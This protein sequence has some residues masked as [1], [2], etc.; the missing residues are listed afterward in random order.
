[1]MPV[2]ALLGRPAQRRRGIDSLYLPLCRIARAAQRFVRRQRVGMLIVHSADPDGGVA[3]DAVDRQTNPL[4]AGSLIRINQVPGCNRQASIAAL[5]HN[6]I[7]TRV[8]DTPVTQS[9]QKSEIV[10]AWLV[11]TASGS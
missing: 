1:M 9:M 10:V 4:C 2:Q 6:H 7:R 3:R 11:D 5:C 8:R